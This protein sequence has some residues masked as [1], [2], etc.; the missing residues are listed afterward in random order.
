MTRQ[1]S[2]L[3]RDQLLVIG[4]LVAMLACLGV[5][6]FGVVQAMRLART[7]PQSP[8]ATTSLSPH[9]LDSRQRAVTPAWR[10]NIANVTSTTAPD[11]AFGLDDTQA[12][13][14]LDIT[15]T[16]TSAREAEL[17]PVNQLYVRGDAGEYCPMHASMHIVD[18]LQSGPLAPGEA[19]S[20]QLSFAIPKN[21][22]NP[23][24]YVDLG[25]DTQTPSIFAVYK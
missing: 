6:S 2:R 22:A 24:L 8:V 5:A 10:V 25:W 20:G 15:I 19:R 23:L 18:P 16:N 3:S 9:V 17:F 11:P 13:L 21:L 1:H 4:L 7:T 12:L 14:M